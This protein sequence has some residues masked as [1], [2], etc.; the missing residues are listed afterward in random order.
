[1]AQSLLQIRN[2]VARSLASADLLMLCAYLCEFGLIDVCAEGDVR[3]L[4]M[5][6]QDKM[7]RVH[8]NIF[9]TE[10]YY[11]VFVLYSVI[12]ISILE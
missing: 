11:H 2:M 4:K 12:L 9:W 7:A 5:C 1:M 10:S 6:T 8:E 3:M